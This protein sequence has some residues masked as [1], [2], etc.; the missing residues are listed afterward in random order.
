MRLIEPRQAKARLRRVSVR[1]VHAPARDL[2]ACCQ[3]VVYRTSD[4]FHA[5]NRLLTELNMLLIIN[6]IIVYSVFVH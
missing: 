3:Y 6:I 4:D 5:S 2:H 1:K